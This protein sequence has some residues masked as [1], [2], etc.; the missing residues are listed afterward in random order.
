MKKIIYAVAICA[1][2]SAS[3]EGIWSSQVGLIEKNGA[4]ELALQPQSAIEVQITIAHE[5]FTAGEYA[6][7]AQKYLGLRA[8]L[9]GKDSYRVVSASLNLAKEDHYTQSNFIAPEAKI[10]TPATLAVNAE[11]AKDMSAEH[12]AKAAAEA[13]FDLR[14]LAMEL[15]AGEVGEGVFGAGLGSTIDEFR[16]QE[17]EY[18]KL[19]MGEGSEQ[20]ITKRFTIY[21]ESDKKEYVV[22]R[23]D[24][25]RGL[26]AADD[27]TAEP[28]YIQITPPALELM[29]GV[30]NVELPLLKGQKAVKFAVAGL[31]TCL[32]SVGGEVL[33][34]AKMPLYQFGQIVE[35]SVTK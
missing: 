3:A 26:L 11:Q 8:P 12:S 4:Y 33:G 19:F 18:L 17:S 20:I 34:E 1:A 32:L 29:D 13:I 27:L 35:F 10:F 5:K 7:Y 15:M 21:P 16:R 25:L 24:P 28:I 6:R 23:F 31:S 2:V 30:R 9:A 22:A 14:K